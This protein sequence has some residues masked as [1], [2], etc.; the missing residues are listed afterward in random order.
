VLVERSDLPVERGRRVHLRSAL[1]RLHG[2]LWF[3]RSRAGRRRV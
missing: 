3:Q 1:G 2:N